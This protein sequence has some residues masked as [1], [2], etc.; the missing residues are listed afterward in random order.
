VYFNIRREAGRLC[1]LVLMDTISDGKKELMASST[2]T[3]N[4]QR[5]ELR[6]KG[7]RQQAYRVYQG[8]L[9]E[10]FAKNWL[11]VIPIET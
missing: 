4:R 10:A 5:S 2:I 9:W 1:V 7:E 6:S 11:A 3:R 8:A